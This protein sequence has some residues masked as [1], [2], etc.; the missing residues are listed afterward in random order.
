MKPSVVNREYLP[1][2]HLVE[3]NTVP[4]AREF[5]RRFVRPGLPVVFRGAALGLGAVRRWNCGYLKAAAGSR[6]VPIEYSPDKEFALPERIGKDR[7]HSSFGSFVDYLIYGD[8]A[9]PTTYYLAQVDTLKY[10]PE[11]VGDIVRPSFAPLAKIMRPPYLWMGIGGNASTLHYDSYDNLYAMVSG[12]KHITLFPPTD[13]R[14]LYPYTDDRRNRHFSRINLRTPDLERFPGLLD[15]QP[16]EC[17]LCRG[18]ILYIPEGWWH[19]LRSQGLNVAVN[20]WWIEDEEPCE[21]RRINAG[22]GFDAKH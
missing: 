19:Y 22:R 15:A 17:V 20:W 3:T 18:D 6:R 5:H 12:R 9:S 11:L 14:H 21:L 13:R 2:T 16:V 10:L 1:L 4:G 7:V 8:T